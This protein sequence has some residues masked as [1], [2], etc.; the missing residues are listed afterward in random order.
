MGILHDSGWVHR[1]L[2]YGNILVDDRGHTKLIDFEYAKKARDRAVPEFRVVRRSLG[3]VDSAYIFLRQG[4]AYFMATE[5]E[6]EG[7][8]FRPRQLLPPYWASRLEM[9]HQKLF[10]DEADLARMFCFD[11]PVPSKPP[12]DYSPLHDVESLWWLLA[13]YVLEWGEQDGPSDADHPREFVRH[14][15]LRQYSRKLFQDHERLERRKVVREPGKF[16]SVVECLRGNAHLAGQELE[17]FRQ[18]LVACFTRSERDAYA[19]AHPDFAGLHDSLNVTIS[20]IRTLLPSESAAVEPVVNAT[21]SRKRR[22]GADGAAAVKQVA[23][24]KRPRRV[25]REHR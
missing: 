4:T 17:E 5:V 10:E 9:K 20:R 21:K 24:A 11:A 16:A 1:D 18:Q 6:N 22:R 15:T 23:S 13:F 25:C 19:I 12:F 3:S 2:S 14:S 8:L 7:H